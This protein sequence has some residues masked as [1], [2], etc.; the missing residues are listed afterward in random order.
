MK[1]CFSGVVLVGLLV[2]L[3]PARAQR[4]ATRADSLQQRLAIAPPD[5]GRVLL[6]TQLAYELAEVDSVASARRARPALQL[7][8]V[9]RYARC[10]CQAYI[11][12]G[13][14]LR[15]T[16]DFPAAQLLLLQGLHL[17]EALHDQSTIVTVYNAMGQL[18]S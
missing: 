14:G 13:V 18:N 3:W 7:T 11:R 8:H 6:L 15:N 5:T 16:G 1:T 4:P 12:R 10:E 2:A 9:L 17:A